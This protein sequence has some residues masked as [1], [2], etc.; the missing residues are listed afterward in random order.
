[1]LRYLCQQDGIEAHASNQNDLGRNIL[2]DHCWYNPKV[3]TIELLLDRFPWLVSEHGGCD[4]ASIG[5]I[6][7]S[8]ERTSDNVKAVKLLL[9]H[10]QAT[11]G[12]IDV[13]KFLNE[14]T[15]EGWPDMCRMLIVDGHADAGKVFKVS[16]SGQLELKGYCFKNRPFF[17]RG[18]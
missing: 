4:R 1:M 8:N 3:E 6:K 12:L 13:E 5:I 17:L 11:P 18:A 9:Q 10:T 16:S 2:A 14:A 15:W 7:Y